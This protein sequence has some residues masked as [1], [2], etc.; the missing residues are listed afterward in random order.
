MKTVVILQLPFL[1]VVLERKVL[2]AITKAAFPLVQL[3]L[4]RKPVNSRLFSG[5]TNERL[6]EFAHFAPLGGISHCTI[7]LTRIDPS[8]LIRIDPG[9]GALRGSRRCDDESL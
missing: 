4:M 6:V 5:R 9:E 1:M 3:Y 8:L 2:D 7:A